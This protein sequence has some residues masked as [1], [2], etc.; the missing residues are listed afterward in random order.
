MMGGRKGNR[1]EGWRKEEMEEVGKTF[2]SLG[3]FFFFSSDRDKHLRLRL[4]GTPLHFSFP[5][6]L[7]FL[8]LRLS[9]SLLHFNSAHSLHLFPLYLPSSALALSSP[10][11]VYFFLSPHLPSGLNFLPFLILCPASLSF[12]FYIYF[13]SSSLSLSFQVHHFL[14][15]LN[16][17]FGCLVFP[18][19]IYSQFLFSLSFSLSFLPFTTSLLLCV[20]CLSLLPVPTLSTPARGLW[21]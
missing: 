9:L 16:V 20:P 6:S 18:V 7:L 3:K 17:Y 1:K 8:T 11:R 10:L 14:I 13:V 15:H 5:S 21:K 4:S 19:S 12:P 2:I